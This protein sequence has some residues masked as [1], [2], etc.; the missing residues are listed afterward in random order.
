MCKP[1]MRLI[2]DSY[3]DRDIHL[4]WKEN[5]PALAYRPDHVQLSGYE[6]VNVSG[7]RNDILYQSGEVYSAV[8]AE[9][10]LRRTLTY[11]L[12]TGYMP[13]VF[14]VV[15]TW[16][17][18]WIPADAVPARVTL[19]VTNFLSTVFVIQQEL[20]KIIRVDYTT[21]MQ[22]LLMANLIFVSLAMVEYLIVLN[23]TIKKKTKDIK[24]ISNGRTNDCVLEEMGDA[25]GK[26]E[27]DNQTSEDGYKRKRFS[28]E[29]VHKVDYYCR[30]A[31][32]IVYV[33]FLSAYV[34]YYKSRTR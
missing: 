16:A 31:V 34:G 33:I 6:V 3:T 20:G 18:F 1:F 17:T 11:H 30:I 8:L 12:F 15:L 13:S 29:E 32:P 4:L 26:K 21:A 7:R 10:R 2:L 22:L 19:I 28:I 24:Y 25:N 27:E 5:E 23:I 9:I 14:L